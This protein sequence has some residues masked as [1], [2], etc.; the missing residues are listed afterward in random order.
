MIFRKGGK[1]SSNLKFYYD[2]VEIEIVNKFTYLGIVFTSGGSLTTA[3]STLAGQAQKAVFK[4]NK[5]LYKF[6]YITPKHKLDLFDKLVAPILNYGSEVCGF[7]KDLS[8]VRVHL[9]FC[10]KLL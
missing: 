6:T 9:Q 8:I 2:N 10:E 4:L 1:I 3:Q 7:A 5:Y